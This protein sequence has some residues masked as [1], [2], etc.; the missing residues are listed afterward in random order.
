MSHMCKAIKERLRSS[1]RL[2]WNFE[3]TGLVSFKYDTEVV[4]VILVVQKI[5]FVDCIV[6]FYPCRTFVCWLV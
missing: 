3:R 1:L 5:S 6:N 2:K 4:E